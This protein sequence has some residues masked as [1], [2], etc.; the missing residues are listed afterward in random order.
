MSD[1][2]QYNTKFDGFSWESMMQLLLLFEDSQSIAYSR[3]GK[4]NG[5]DA[6]SGNGETVY[7]AKFHTQCSI[8]NCIADLKSEMSKIK[9]YRE[10]LNYW[11]PVKKWIL[12]TNVVENPNDREKWNDAVEKCDCCGLEIELWNWSKIWKLLK[13]HPEVKQDFLESESRCILLKKEFQ[14]KCQKEYLPESFD[15]EC[16]GREKELQLFKD[17]LESDK[18]IWSVSGPGGMGKSRFLIECA[19]FVDYEKW[20]V[21]FGVSETLK[22]TQSWNKRV[23]LERP[24]ILFIDELNDVDLLNRILADLVSGAM[25]KWKIIF[26]ERNSNAKTILEIKQPKYDFIRTDHTVLS[27]LNFENRS[28]LTQNLLNAV[29]TSRNI[30]FLDKD[31]AVRNI[32]EVSDGSPLWISLAVKLILLQNGALGKLF[33]DKA[34]NIRHLYSCSIGP[35]LSQ[36]PLSNEQYDNILKWS[37]LYKQIS[38]NQE[39]IIGLICKKANVERNI[40]FKTYQLMVDVGLMRNFGYENKVYSICPDVIRED[41]L[42][43]KILFNKKISDWGNLVI[44]GL[45]A[46]EIPCVED[47]VE[48]LSRIENNEDEIDVLGKFVESIETRF[49]SEPLENHSKLW[50][51]VERM[52]VNRPEEILDFVE[53]ILKTYRLAKDVD[54]YVLQLCCNGVKDVLSVCL[55]SCNDFASKYKCLNLIF[56]LYKRNDFYDHRQN[57]LEDFLSPIFEGDLRDAYA[58]IV[59]DFLSQFFSQIK[60]HA[61]QQDDYP[62]LNVLLTGCFKTEYHSGAYYAGK[63]LLTSGSLDVSQISKFFIWADEIQNVLASIDLEEALSK[64]LIECYGHLFGNLLRY[65][66]INDRDEAIVYDF[67]TKRLQWCAA[68]ISSGF[69]LQSEKRNLLRD[70]VWEWIIKYGKD[71][72]LVVFA[73]ECEKSYCVE[74]SDKEIIEFLSADYRDDDDQMAKNLVQNRLVNKEIDEIYSFVEKLAYYSYQGNYKIRMIAADYGDLMTQENY[75]LELAGTVAIQYQKDAFKEFYYG[76]LTGFLAHWKTSHNSV[77]FVKKLLNH[78]LDKEELLYRCLSENRIYTIQSFSLL[79]EY[80]ADKNTERFA[81]MVASFTL[82]LGESFFTRVESLWVDWTENERVTYLNILIQNIQSSARKWSNTPF[83]W[84]ENS[85]SWLVDKIALIHNLNVFEHSCSDFDEMKSLFSSLK[86]IQWMKKVAEL[87]REY[88]LSFCED[89]SLSYFVKSNFDLDERNAYTELIRMMLLENVPYRLENEIVKLDSEN[90]CLGKIVVD[91]FN[92]TQS[93]DEKK[94]FAKIAGYLKDDSAAWM[95][96]STEVCKYAKRLPKKEKHQL[97]STLSWKGTQVYSGAYGHVPKM[98]YD[99]V[100]HF[101]DMLKKETLPERRDYWQWKL[102]FAERVLKDEEERAKELRGE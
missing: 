69:G 47:V 58:E 90:V 38:L 57:A 14:E 74:S 27:R 73:E 56:E 77:D 4:D 39:K 92:S 65:P 28:K 101:R 21:Y 7:Q 6:V 98:Y 88:H 96:I 42:K 24:S 37:S 40:L 91:E 43:E 33:E 23:V 32:C 49:K 52:A 76:F 20:N 64:I 5:I 53:D 31:R 50:S 89:F 84:N 46:N 15:V 45:I 18:K 97:W 55:Y 1:F 48:S 83:I 86:N 54:E 62:L 81:R 2:S 67:L 70:H 79:T 71:S 3:P 82:F 35:S 60:K 78:N 22:I 26:S 102:D 80:V 13:K 34:T 87:R 10:K 12:F 75:V 9:G 30:R 95:E 63:M 36:I 17:F 66:K 93:D 85:A 100:E 16:V 51:V 25:Q 29:E 11:K 41:I 19:N 94:C 44:D 72:P 61:L 99:N 8:E 59:E 68:F